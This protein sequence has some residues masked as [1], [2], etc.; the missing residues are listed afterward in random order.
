MVENKHDFLRPESY[1]SAASVNQDHFKGGGGNDKIHDD[2][3]KLSFSELQDQL[4]PY[5]PQSI[6]E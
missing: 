6:H 1:T 2:I 4:Q 3:S 5:F